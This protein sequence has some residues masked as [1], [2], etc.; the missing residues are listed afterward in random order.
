MNRKW[1][2]Y[3][4]V[5]SAMSG[6][7]IA[8]PAQ[9]AAIAEPL[10]PKG[11][12]GAGGTAD[13][14]IPTLTA[15]LPAQNPTKTAVIIAPGGGY[16]NLSMDKEGSAI[17]K[18]LNDRGVA[19]F[20]LKYRLGMKY[21][22]PIELGD[23]QRAIRTVRARAAQYG[24]ASDHIGMCGFS[25]GGHLTAS[26]GT[27]YDLGPA[28]DGDAIDKESARP[29][30]LILAYPVITMTPQYAHKGS[31]KNLLGETP[32]PAQVDLLSPEKHVTAQTPPTFIYSTT[33]DGT[34]PIMNSVMFYA[35]LVAAKVPVEMHLYQHGPHGTGLAQQYPDLKGW[36]DLLATWMRSKGMMGPG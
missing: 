29:D 18:W 20:V 14:D 35:A 4:L 9:S 8:V 7:A 15:Y 22:H 28:A 23:A 11:A 31:V 32:D 24:L 12:P 27:L 2:R 3:V 16:A 19:G 33:D 25:A 13:I 30:F 10:W 34:V 36:P 21:H 6:L 1:L 26:A 17:A 5:A